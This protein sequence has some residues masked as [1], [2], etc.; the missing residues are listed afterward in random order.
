VRER[1]KEGE[2]KNKEHNM[3]LIKSIIGEERKICVIQKELW[4]KRVDR[5]E[6]LTGKNSV[7]SVRTTL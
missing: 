4:R 6:V 2:K 3:L 7:R 1:N 5:K